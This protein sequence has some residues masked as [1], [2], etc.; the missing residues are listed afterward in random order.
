VTEEPDIDTR[1]GATF[2]PIMMR[3]GPVTP[4]AS[5]K[6]LKGMF[7]LSNSR[8]SIRNLVGGW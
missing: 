1:G 3:Q 5:D 4:E 6:T 2:R 8:L 7:S